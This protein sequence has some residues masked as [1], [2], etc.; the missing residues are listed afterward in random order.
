MATNNPLW[1]D[2]DFSKM[3]AE[4]KI[5]GVDM[6]AVMNAQRKNIEAV[7]AANRLA[8]EGMQAVIQRQTEVLR[9]TTEEL[10]KMMSDM[11]SAGTP[12]DRVSKQADLVKAAFE[13][14]LSNMKEMAEMI[15]KSNTEAAEV[16]SKR[17]SENLEEIK[18]ISAK[19]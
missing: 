10:T 12:E 11:M 16:I 13:K 5:P 8:V 1:P 15:A 17:I 6:D 4:F 7:T 2:M 3:M 9:T 19:A 14:T 18:G